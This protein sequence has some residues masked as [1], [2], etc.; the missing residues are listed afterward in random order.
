MRLT[1]ELVPETSWFNILNRNFVF[2]YSRL[3]FIFRLL[4]LIAV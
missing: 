3:P 1:I 2:H 4:N